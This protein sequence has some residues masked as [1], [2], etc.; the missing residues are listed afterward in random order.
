MAARTTPP[1]IS[2]WAHYPHPQHALWIVDRLWPM[3]LMAV[4]LFDDQYH[5]G[6]LHWAEEEENTT[7]TATLR[8][9]ASSSDSENNSNKN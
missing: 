8:S 5:C 7:A 6:H 1:I 3:F 2:S 9:D 4:L